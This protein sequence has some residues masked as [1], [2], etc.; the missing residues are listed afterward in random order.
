MALT[1]DDVV[2]ARAS[3]DS[4]GPYRLLN[5]IMTGQTSQVWEAMHDIK[6]ERFAIKILLPECAK[7]SE[8]VSFMKN[9]FAVGSKLEHPRVIRLHELGTYQRAPYLA[10]EFFPY[11]NVKQYV[12]RGIEQV[13]FRIPQIIEQAAEGLAYFNEQG[14]IH[15]DVKPDN[16]LI[17]P[18]GDVKLIDFALAMKVP[19]GLA[20]LFASKPKKIQGT[21]SYMSPEQIR[22]LMLDQ[23]TDVYS[24]GCAVFEMVTGKPPF[25]GASSNDLLMKHL[26]S[27]PPVLEAIDR[28]VT[29]EFGELV[30]RA[31]AKS[32]DQRPP[33]VQTFLDEFRTLRVFKL[34]HKPP[35]GD[36]KRRPGA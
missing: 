35:E 23:R 8:H 5:L 11:P 33:S 28:N 10:M 32:P 24:L 22:G 3:Q 14:W 9:E 34:P 30:R 7:E 16:F 20:R 6:R 17:S 19:K 26:K 18:D 27:P 15:R 31:M 36:V 12:R 2:V 21:R 1:K 13:G 29:P 4:I 25:T